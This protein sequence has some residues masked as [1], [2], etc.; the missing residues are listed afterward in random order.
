MWLTTHPTNSQES[1]SML[2]TWIKHRTDSVILHKKCA[3]NDK[4]VNS[5][6]LFTLEINIHIQKTTKQNFKIANAVPF[7]GRN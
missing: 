1:Q 7:L 3:K 2:C 4:H 6:P 5:H